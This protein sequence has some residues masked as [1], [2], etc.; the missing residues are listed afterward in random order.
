MSKETGSDLD[1]ASQSVG[2]DAVGE[3]AVRSRYLAPGYWRGPDL[4]EAAFL[5]DPQGG[6]ARTY[7]T[8]DLGRMR[9]DGWLEYL[10]RKHFQFKIRGQ[11]VALPEIEGALLG[12][13]TMKMDR[14]ALPAPGRARPNLGTPIVPARTP[15]EAA[16]GAIW[17]E[18]L[19]LAEVGIHDNFFWLG[20]ELVVGDASHV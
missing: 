1:E 13:A 19:E 15:V 2:P 8:G 9:A 20:G 11:W 4:T 5:A 18:V 7:R 6:S 3:I 10:G 17:A 12:L 14:S 16:V